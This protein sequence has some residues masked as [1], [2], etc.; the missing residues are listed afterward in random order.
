M[1]NKA[2]SLLLAITLAV[3]AAGC[4]SNGDDSGGDTGGGGASTGAAAANDAVVIGLGATP[5]GLDPQKSDDSGA[6]AVLHRVYEALTD[7]DPDGKIEPV[8]AAEMPK[9]VNDT[10]WEVPLLPDVKF[11]D[12]TPFNADAVVYS[13]KRIISPKQATE[14]S[15]ISTIKDVTKVDDLTVRITTKGPDPLL[16]YRLKVAQMLAPDAAEAPGWPEETNGTGPYTL[17]RYDSG[18]EAVLEYNENW[19]GD[20]PQ[21]KRVVIRFMPDATTR[22]QALKA[23]DID[24]DPGVAPDQAAEVPKVESSPEPSATGLVRLNAYS[25]VLADKRVRQALNYAIDKDAIAEQLYG[26]FASPAQCQLT[27]GS[28]GDA[29][30]DLKAYPFDVA[31]AKAL[32]DEAGAAGE[33]I[34]LTWST[35][36]FPQ[37]RL[38]GEIVAQQIEQTGLKVK[39]KLLEYNA[40]LKQIFLRGPEAP[41]ALWTE[42]DNALGNAARPIEYYY[43][44]DGP[45]SAFSNAEIDSMYKSAST[46]LDDA[47]RHEEYKKL[48]EVG[49]DEA[50]VIFLTAR[51]NI[52]GMSERLNYKPQ[53]DNYPKLHYELM[54]ISG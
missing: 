8:L 34:D 13:L 25:G 7:F 4:G 39:L 29:N 16:P 12:G 44:T 17:T 19:R 49:C 47:S 45:V 38:L 28:S 46:N 52:F 5:A 24:L 22:I 53:S 10:T 27:P 26:E 1:G 40:W 3:V 50:P 43:T 32:V 31:K 42:T 54:S 15:E 41:Q 37:D 14:L 33:T 9:L 21:V 48:L 11:A 23:G 18:S 20:G 35:G 51:R 36:V 30:P 2:T 6:Y